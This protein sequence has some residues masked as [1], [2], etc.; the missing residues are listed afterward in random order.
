MEQKKSSII[1]T[2]KSISFEDCAAE[3]RTQIDKESFERA[4]SNSRHVEVREISYRVQGRSVIGFVLRPKEAKGKLP[5]IIYNRGGT[6]DYGKI[7]SE[8]IFL[9]MAYFTNAGYI[10]VASQYSGSTGSGGEDDWGGSMTLTDVLRLKDVLAEIP[11]ADLTRIG[12]Y[13][14][15][16]GGM[17]TYCALAR[18]RWIQAAVSIAG[19]SDLSDIAQRRSDMQQIYKKHIGGGKVTLQERSA[20]HFIEKFSKRTPLLLMHGTR[21]T[22]VHYSQSIRLAE[23]LIE[24]GTP[25]RL[26]LFED[27]NHGLTQFRRETLSATVSWFDKYVKTAAPGNKISVKKKYGRRLRDARGSRIKP[28]T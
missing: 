5:C 18:T 27:G 14:K 19:V 3:L 6:A 22:R 16:R 20:L 9:P 8:W 11:G 4:R 2:S 10:V 24:H 26:M 15:S 1:V 17:M 28:R 7:T 12:M 23:K 21:D 25:T 13:G